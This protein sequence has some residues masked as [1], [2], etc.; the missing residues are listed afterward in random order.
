MIKNNSNKNITKIHSKSE[1]FKIFF[2]HLS[3]Y[4]EFFS[5][6]LTQKGSGVQGQSLEL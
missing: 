2:I 4:F 6:V 5:L 1:L 3:N